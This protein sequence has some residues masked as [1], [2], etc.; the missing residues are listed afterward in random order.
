MLFRNAGYIICR[1]SNDL[2]FDMQNWQDFINLKIH[3]ILFLT[4]DFYYWQYKLK[5][6]YSSGIKYGYKFVQKGANDKALALIN[7]EGC[8]LRSTKILEHFQKYV[9][10]TTFKQNHMKLAIEL[11]YLLYPAKLILK[12]TELQLLILKSAEINE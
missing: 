11:L 5:L 8:L 4:T 1:Y 10:C 3:V 9:N 12:K 6:R 7:S 2:K